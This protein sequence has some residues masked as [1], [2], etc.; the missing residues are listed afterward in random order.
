MRPLKP[1]H[2]DGMTENEGVG[3]YD[4]YEDSEEEGTDEATFKDED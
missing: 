2:Q 4:A 1:F 3:A